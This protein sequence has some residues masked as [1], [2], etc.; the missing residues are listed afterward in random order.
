[1]TFPCDA[2]IGHV[3][4]PLPSAKV[5]LLDVPEMGYVAKEGK[6]EILVK[7]PIVFQGY[8]KNPQLTAQTVDADGW[9]HTG[10]IGMFNEVKIEKNTNLLQNT[11][12]SIQ[13]CSKQNQALQI[14]DRKKNIFKLSQGEYVAPEKIENVYSQSSLVAQIFVYG[15]S[16]KSSL[17]GVIVPDQIVLEL[18]CRNNNINGTFQEMC[19]HKV[20]EA[21]KTTLYLIFPMN[22]V[23]G[24]TKSLVERITNV[25]PKRRTQIF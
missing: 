12:Y 25:G 8:F 9:L 20:T 11:R 24:C 19:K 2:S 22:F 18:W 3:G 16:L 4:P 15:E 21:I 23:P 6:G 13:F 10:D 1:M 17:V 7:G 14:I 5:K